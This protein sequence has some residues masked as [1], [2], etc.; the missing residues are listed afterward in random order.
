[1]TLYISGSGRV[2]H[3]VLERGH[4]YTLCGLKVVA[5][6]SIVTEP[7]QHGVLCKHCERLQ[8]EPQNNQQHF[9]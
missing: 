4:S 7:P 2:Y 8:T 3:I 5:F 1:M 6:K 9:Q